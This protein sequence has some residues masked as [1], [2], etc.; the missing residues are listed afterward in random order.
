MTSH[1]K[2]EIDLSPATFKETEVLSKFDY[3]LLLVS[4]DQFNQ[5]WL[6]SWADTTEDSQEHLDA[7]NRALIQDSWFV[8]RVSESRLEQLLNENISL[9]EAILFYESKLY[10]ATSGRP[11]TDASEIVKWRELKPNTIPLELLPVVD[12]SIAGK[13]L[14]PRAKENSVQ[15]ESH[16]Y[17]T[18]KEKE[19]IPLELIGPFMDYMQKVLRWASNFV[20][21]GPPKELV[22]PEKVGLLKLNSIEPGS[23]RMLTETHDVK[24]K[25]S[26]S[27]M[28]ALNHLKELIE[29]VKTKDD[30]EKFE[31][32]IGR[33]AL[34]NVYYLFRLLQL[35]K[36]NMS[37]KS[38]SSDGALSSISLPYEEVKG[39][40][41]SLESYFKKEES[42]SELVI[43]LSDDAI[44]KLNRPINGQGGWQN[45][46]IALK[47]QVNLNE[48][49][50]VLSPKLTERVIRYSQLYG[51]GG[52]QGRLEPILKELRSLGVIFSDLR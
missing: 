18:K 42:V 30:V 12:I 26:T 48:K 4:T 25:E 41:G 37:I 38:T 17:F 50:L 21:H 40:V 20:L 49:I 35:Q 32:N 2:K 52:W 39:L 36:V 5:K 51:Q 27:I 8:F 13:S 33:E 16:L 28:E 19:G 46:A 34:L 31:L 3:P 6:L 14:M 7:D 1:D 9:R 11:L 44:E 45:L 22:I 47:K 15:L 10:L 24:G 43:R 29:N 23:V